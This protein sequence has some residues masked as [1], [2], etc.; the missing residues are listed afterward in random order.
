MKR[1]TI[2]NPI[3]DISEGSSQLEFPTGLTE[4]LVMTDRIAVQLLSL[5]KPVS[6]FPQEVLILRAR[7]N[8]WPACKKIKIKNKKNKGIRHQALYP[9][10]P[11]LRLN[12]RL[13]LRQLASLTSQ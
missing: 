8:K 10:C 5:P 7:P 3:Q 13:S 12:P 11:S 2:L 9:E 6:S 4:V 1:P